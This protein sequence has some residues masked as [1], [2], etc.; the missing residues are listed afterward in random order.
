MSK[1]LSS[2]GKVHAFG[3]PCNGWLVCGFVY[4]FK[5]TARK[6][7]IIDINLTEIE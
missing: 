7:V 4:V 6:R 1:I 5:S 2:L 3:E